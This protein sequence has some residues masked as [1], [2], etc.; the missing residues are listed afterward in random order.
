MFFY[1]LTKGLFP[2]RLFSFYIR[3]ISTLSTKLLIPFISNDNL[4]KTIFLNNNLSDFQ[5]NIG[6]SFGP[7]GVDIN[8]LPVWARGYSGKGIVVSVLDDG[9]CNL[10]FKL[11]QLKQF[12]RIFRE[13]SFYVKLLA[14]SMISLN[15]TK[16][17][18]DM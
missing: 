8:V 15:L 4:L 17:I 10:S 2:K 7:T 6:Q 9:E 13:M 16:L 1:R 14:K 5:Q 12:V 3:K 11:N 18:I